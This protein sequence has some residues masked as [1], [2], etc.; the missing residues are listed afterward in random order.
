MQFDEAG[1]LEVVNR[2]ARQGAPPDAALNKIV[3]LA[4]QFLSVPIALISIVDKDRIWFKAKYGMEVSQIE[5]EPGL[6]ASAILQDQPWVVTDARTDSRTQTNKLVS[7]EFGWQFYAGVP[8][9]VKTGHNLGT[10]CVAHRQPRPISLDET[11]IL[12]SLASLVVEL[13]ELRLSANEALATASGAVQDRAVARERADHL[14]KDARLLS[15]IVESSQDAIVSKD[16]NGIVTS[17]NGAAQEIFGY[18]AEDM[19]GQSITRVIPQN[20]LHE[21]TYVLESI[22]RGERIEHFETVRRRKNGKL[23]PISLTVSPIRDEDGAIVG[24]S[25]IARDISDRVESRN[26]IRALLREVNHRV[27]NQFAVILS[28]VKQTSQRTDSAQQFEAGIRKRI[29]ALARSHDLLVSEDWRGATIHALLEAQTEML[30]H[31]DRIVASGPSILLSPMAVQYLGMAFHELGANAAVY[32]ALSDHQGHVDIGWNVSDTQGER[33]L[34]LIWHERDGPDVGPSSKDGFG[35][36][37]LKRIAPA[38]LGGNG[39]LTS[40]HNGLT[41]ELHAP[42][43]HVETPEVADGD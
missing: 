37:V 7:G 27:K 5:R 33:W 41:W 8:L 11:T 9:A 34:E 21:E 39:S 43:G 29:M 6:C 17:W 28:M 19:I 13:F 16:L 42:M 20:R 38:A 35:N 31:K 2:Y 40:L 24:A 14:I 22:K 23:I 30:P 25:K 3:T 10:L 15:A 32:G 12:R 4:A 18:S 1:R 36:V 26:R